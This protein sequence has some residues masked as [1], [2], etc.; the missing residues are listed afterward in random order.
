MISTAE[1][2]TDNSTKQHLHPCSNRHNLSQHAVSD[3][4]S[5]PDLAV[6]AALKM[7]TQIDTHDDLG[8]EHEH[9][10]VGEFGVDVGRE[11]PSFVK[12]A[13]EVSEDCNTSGDDLDGYMPARADYAQYHTDWE[14]D[15]PG[16]YLYQNV[17]P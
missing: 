5:S 7:Q 2:K 13:Q 17:D 16:E 8:N 6:D 9:Q 4:N 10:D 3:D 12:M 1:S 14:E 15:A 11:L